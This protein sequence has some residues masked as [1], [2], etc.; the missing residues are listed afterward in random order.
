MCSPWSVSRA[1]TAGSVGH[2][3]ERGGGKRAEEGRRGKGDSFLVSV[4]IRLDRYIS[5][6]CVLEVFGGFLLLVP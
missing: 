4:D 1:R 2:G 3:M 5:S 6:R